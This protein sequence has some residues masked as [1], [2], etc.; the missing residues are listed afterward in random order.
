MIYYF[1]TRNAL[2]ERGVDLA[3][4]DWSP[5]DLNTCQQQLGKFYNIIC[6]SWMIYIAFTASN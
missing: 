4:S 3:F 1:T 2:L 6:L 5:A